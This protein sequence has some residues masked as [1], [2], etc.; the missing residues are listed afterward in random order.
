MSRVRWFALSVFVGATW[1]LAI[2][3]D[4]APQPEPQQ[5]PI[6]RRAYLN[7]VQ[8]SDDPRRVP[9]PPGPRGPEGTTVLRGGL[10]FDGT[11]SEPAAGTVVMERNRIAAV[12]AEGVTDWPADA[13]VL[14]VS[15]HTVLPGLMDLHTHLTYTELDVPQALTV[16]PAHAALR[17]VERLH[18]FIGSGITSV[19]DTSS[20]GTVPFILKE[21]VRDNRLP[22]PRV[23]A[24]GQLITAT[25]GHS[26]EG[27]SVHSGVYGAVVEASGADG[28]REAVREQFKRGAD[29]I[30]VASHFS[31]EE[32]AAAV[33]EAHTLGLRITVDSETVY[34][35]WAVEAGVDAI[36]HP[37]PRTDEVIAMM[38]QRGIASVPT[39]VPYDYIFEW[40]GSYHSSTSRR[41]ELTGETT[42]AM[43]RKMKE[44]GVLIGLGTD[45]VFDWFRD[46]PYAYIQE[47]EVYVECGFTP[48]EA[49]LAATRDNARIL[50]MDDKLGTLEVGKLAD[51]LVVEGNPLEG[52]AAWRTSPRSSGTATGWCGTAWS[53]PRHRSSACPRARGRRPGGK[54]ANAARHA[55]RSRSRW[56]ATAE[57]RSP[58][59]I[60]RERET[61]ADDAAPCQRERRTS[62][63]PDAAVADLPE[64]E[65][66]ISYR[67]AEVPAL[68]L[69]SSGR[70]RRATVGASSPLR[71]TTSLTEPGGP[72]VRPTRRRGGSSAG[73]AVPPTV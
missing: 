53:S 36:E 39:V 51:V 30:K 13:R 33:D 42:R 21:W 35:E 68:D 43:L 69:S 5:R 19:R 62:P 18:A 60:A 37:L 61:S 32:I 52:F 29:L 3:G 9:A 26:A 17:G 54:P 8:T 23:F 48:T 2:P 34:T 12:L 40:M 72:A 41:F 71:G 45:L 58:T 20:F 15:G 46:L 31:R 6:D 59:G 56:R 66:A 7:D 73:G 14:D 1:V 25:G 38:A 16:H 49:L 50:G 64:S 4:A 55:N 70:R 47:L 24:A 67:F 63:I 10:V 11:G 27:L 22:G 44:A 57:R 65:R 28:F